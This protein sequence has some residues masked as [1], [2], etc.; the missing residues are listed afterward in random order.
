M[1]FL[2]AGV[3][4]SH[5][6]SWRFLVA[7]ARECRAAG[8]DLPNFSLAPLTRELSEADVQ[9]FLPLLNHD[10]NL[11]PGETIKLVPLSSYLGDR[12]RYR[13]APSVGAFEQKLELGRD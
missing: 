10:L 4:A 6:S 11:P 1:P 3:R 13:P 8:L 9:M 7:A 12:E 2:T 5:Y